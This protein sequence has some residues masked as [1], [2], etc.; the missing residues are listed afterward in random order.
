ML[1]RLTVMLI[2]SSVHLVFTL[3]DELVHIVFPDIAGR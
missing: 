3:L 2:Q 1:R